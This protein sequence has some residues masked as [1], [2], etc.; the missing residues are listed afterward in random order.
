[1]VRLRNSI[2]AKLPSTLK[3]ESIRYLKR[4][5]VDHPLILNFSGTEDASGS[6]FE[7]KET[8]KAVR[9]LVRFLKQFYIPTRWHS[10]PTNSSS[11]PK[12]LLISLENLSKP[13]LDLLLPI[14][15]SEG[16]DATVLITVDELDGYG[17]PVIGITPSELKDYVQD[18][19]VELGIVYNNGSRSGSLADSR[20][21]IQEMC[22]AL[23][24]CVDL[25]ISY[26]SFQGLDQSMPLVFFIRAKNSFRVHTVAGS[27]NTAWGAIPGQIYSR[28]DVGLLYT[29]IDVDL[30]LRPIYVSLPSGDLQ[31]ARKSEKLRE[32]EDS[33]Y[34]LY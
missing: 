31:Q 13:A 11:L 15:H 19:N 16:I 20:K 18:Y 5:E 25:P 12:S 7:F 10:V 9:S 3:V 17:A 29:G 34:T 1:M 32:P 2:L 4:N 27:S 33:N 30:A 23:T 8:S 28:C 22:E 14:F 21:A 6:Y 24:N 26:I